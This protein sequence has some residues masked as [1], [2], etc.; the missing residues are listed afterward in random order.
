MVPSEVPPSARPDR[1]IVV[2]APG[3]RSFRSPFAVDPLPGDF[4]LPGLSACGVGVLRH[5]LCLAGSVVDGCLGGRLRS[6]EKNAPLLPAAAL[7]PGPFRGADFPRNPWTERRRT[8][9]LVPLPLSPWRAVGSSLPARRSETIGQRG[10]RR[11][12]RLHG[13]LS[14]RR[15]ARDERRLEGERM[16]CLHEVR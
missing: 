7:Q 5:G 4:D 10:V 3:R 2:H 6:A 16:H 12:R 13:R 14:G 15:R 8:A 11:L 9:L 1:V